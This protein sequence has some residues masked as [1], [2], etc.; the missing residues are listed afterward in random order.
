MP[1][2]ILVADDEPQMRSAL[3]AALESSG[4]E[5][6]LVSD[7]RK[8]LQEAEKRIYDMVITD[9]KMPGLDGLALL[10]R[11]RQDNLSPNVAV[12][13]THLTLPTN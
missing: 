2:R 6:T 9:M 11:I 13:Y 1:P 7:G 12:S 8:A 10:E 4:Y 5:T 3:R